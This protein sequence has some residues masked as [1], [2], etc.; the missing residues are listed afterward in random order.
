MFFKNI[1]HTPGMPALRSLTQE[2]CKFQA[3]LTY[4]ARPCPK[5]LKQNKTKQP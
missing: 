2:N 3:S 4:V 1:M 5:K